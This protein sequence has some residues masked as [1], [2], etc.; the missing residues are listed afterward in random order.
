MLPAPGFMV[1]VIMR[2][3]IGMKAFL[4]SLEATRRREGG[5]VGG[6]GM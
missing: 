4:I 2:Q 6:L 3:D 1:Q 5:S